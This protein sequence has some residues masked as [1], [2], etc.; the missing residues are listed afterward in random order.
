MLFFWATFTSNTEDTVQ[1]FLFTCAV[2]RIPFKL[3]TYETKLYSINKKLVYTIL[4]LEYN[5]SLQKSYKIE[6]NK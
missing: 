1:L 4:P 5:L 6:C 2:V 3:K